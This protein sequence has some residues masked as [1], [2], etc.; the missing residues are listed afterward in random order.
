MSYPLITKPHSFFLL[1][2]IAV[3]L[4]FGGLLTLKADGDIK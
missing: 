2:I 4:T 1:G 3:Y